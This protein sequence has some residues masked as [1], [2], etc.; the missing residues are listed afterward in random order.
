[1]TCRSLQKR[2]TVFWFFFSKLA[3]LPLKYLQLFFSFSW[4]R[5]VTIIVY[6]Y[7]CGVNS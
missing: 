3:G 7:F 1:M 6:N 2:I 4:V 5:S